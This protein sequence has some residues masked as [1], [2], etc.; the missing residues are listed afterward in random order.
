MDRDQSGELSGLESAVLYILQFFT[1]ILP[2][3]EFTSSPGVHKEIQEFNLGG[4]S[5]LYFH[6]QLEGLWVVSRGSDDKLGWETSLP[7]G[8]VSPRWVCLRFV[9]DFRG[10]SYFIHFISR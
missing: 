4:V 8:M 7:L 6:F 9:H 3:N 5:G 10:F 2:V 1:Y